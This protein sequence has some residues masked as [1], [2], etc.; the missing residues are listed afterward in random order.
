MVPKV[1]SMKH[2]SCKMKHKNCKMICVQVSLENVAY[3]ILIFNIIKATDIIKVLKRCEVKKHI[4]FTTQ[5]IP[6]AF[7][8]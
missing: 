8:S 2:K 5:Y 6:Q 7:D 3:Y 4:H 1:Y